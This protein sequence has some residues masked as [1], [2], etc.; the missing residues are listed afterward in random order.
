MTNV[1]ET[2]LENIVFSYQ[3]SNL[4]IINDGHTIQVNYDEGSYIEVDGVRYDLLQFHFHAPSEHLIEGQPSDAELHLVHKSAGGITA[5]VGLFLLQGDV[6]NAFL[7][8]VFDNLPA[9]EGQVLIIDTQVN[10]AYILP[11][12]KG[13]YRYGGSLTTPPCT[14]G[15][16]WFLMTLPIEISVDQLAAFTAIVDAN[17]RPVQPLN[18]RIV[19]EDTSH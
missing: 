2:D 3:P 13:T 8:P 4:N 5:V 19:T 1:A 6:E 15:V 12:G 16:N 17:N 9:E 14:E 11:M 7:A 10:V 18:D